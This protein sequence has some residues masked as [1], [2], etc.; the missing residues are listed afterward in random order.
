MS[1]EIININKYAKVRKSW[2]EKNVEHMREWRRKYRKTDAYKKSRK[3]WLNKSNYYYHYDRNRALR[4]KTD[5]IL[6]ARFLV[7]DAKKRAKAQKLKFNITYKDVVIP[8]LCPALGIK[9]IRGGGMSAASIDRINPK[10][11][12]VKGNVVIISK[13]A[14][15]I[16]SNAT[17]DQIRAVADWMENL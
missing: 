10:K 3:K 13:M 6:W 9:L 4:A 1:A 15:Q 11:G 16:K 7:G 2:R 14:N 17:A 12:Y 5:R 8:E